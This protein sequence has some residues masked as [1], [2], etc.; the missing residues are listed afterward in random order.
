VNEASARTDRGFEEEVL[1]HL[2]AV[3]RRALRLSGAP[4]LA[5][6]LFQETFLRAFK[7]WNHYTQGTAAKS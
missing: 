4:N 1:P 6:N 3:Y 2:E 7:S 5:E